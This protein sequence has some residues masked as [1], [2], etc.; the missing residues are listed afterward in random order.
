MVF[1]V[2]L[3]IGRCVVA[4]AEDPILG[5]RSNDPGSRTCYTSNT[6]VKILTS[7]LRI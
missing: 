1:V 7:L 4:Y 5:S 6:G 2:V 3:L